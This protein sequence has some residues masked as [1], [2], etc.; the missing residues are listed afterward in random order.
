MLR[1]GGALE[2]L[3]SVQGLREVPPSVVRAFRPS[4][5]TLADRITTRIQ[6]E[7]A[8]FAGRADAD[9]REL[10]SFAVHSAADLFLDLLEGRPV[11]GHRVDKLFRRMGRAEA[12]DGRGL[13][14]VRAACQVAGRD[15]WQELRNAADCDDLPASVLGPLGDVL[16]NY[17]QHLV[18]QVQSGY[19]EAQRERAPER[20][21]HQLLQAML[22]GRPDD[23]VRH[24]ADLADW[25]V[26]GECVV[27]VANMSAQTRRPREVPGHLLLHVTDGHVVVVVGA[28]RTADARAALARLP[29]TSPVA[30]S[31]AVP[32]ADVRHAHRWARRALGLAASGWIERTDVID[33]T[34]YRSALW[35]HADPALRRE[36]CDEL[37]APLLVHKRHQRAILAQTLLLWL[38]AHESAP[39]IAEQ[40]GVHEQT[41]R[42][43]LRRLKSAFAPV[44]AEPSQ[45]T[46]LLMVLES[47]APAWL[48]QAGVRSEPESASATTRPG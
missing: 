37:L 15:A 22:A 28:D 1:Q 33:C 25:E 6:R 14:A 41:V 9:R 13:D 10:I 29:L 2:A 8:A 36:L 20:V 24:L 21:R 44:L 48:L 5:P 38:R 23:D 39:V 35:L 11:S 31:W 30:L 46:A 18:D 12:M 7:V 32:A 3:R 19:L 45:K 4:V 16:F 43:R 26:P 47:V 17:L 34:D 27:L 42:R 40:M